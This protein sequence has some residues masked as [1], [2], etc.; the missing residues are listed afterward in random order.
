MKSKQLFGVMI[1]LSGL[2]LT[3]T[4]KAQAATITVT[5]VT[6]DTTSG[7]CTLREAVEAVN[8]RVA[9]DRCAA[10]TGGDEIILPAGTISVGSTRLR[11]MKNVTLK[12]QG[13]RRTTVDFAAASGIDFGN[14]ATILN[15][16]IQE[17]S[18]RHGTN[19]LRFTSSTKGI[20]SNVAVQDGTECVSAQSN[21][22]MTRVIVSGC[23][24]EGGGITNT[25]KLSV[26]SSSI[27]GN[28]GSMAGGIF[29][30]SG[31]LTV[32]NSTIGGNTVTTARFLLDGAGASG[33]LTTAGGTTTINYSTIA[34]NENTNQLGL[35]STNNCGA[36]TAGVGLPG[37]PGHDPIPAGVVNVT[38]SV[39]ANNTLALWDTNMDCAGTITSGGYNLLGTF[40]NNGCPRGAT[41]LAPAN[42]RLIAS[43]PEPIP[44]WRGGM[45]P[46]YLPQ[47]N[48]PLLNA[49]PAGVAPCSAHGLDQRMVRRG[50][51][52]GCEPGAVER[53]YALLVVD[54]PNVLSAGDA[55]THQILW[56]SGYHVTLA[57]DELV[58]AAQA[59]G[60]QTVV[61]SE[62][63]TSTV[64]GNRLRDVTSGVLV[65]EPSLFDD[66]AM[67][68]GGANLGSS[69]GQSLVRVQPTALSKMLGL[70]G[71]QIFN[72]TAVSSAQQFGWGVPAASADIHA[73]MN[74]NA[75]HAAFF[76]YFSGD[77]LSDGSDAAG[78]RTGF[79]AFPAAVPALTDSGA[80]AGYELFV[81][82][83][84]QT[85]NE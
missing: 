47:S 69:T 84:L 6:D 22:S 4:G 23:T 46:S 28:A 18:F 55:A 14:G 2:A 70:G 74:D 40:R 19:T 29:N 51:V 34:F 41:D 1:G 71:S 25:G 73:T 54:D 38:A 81:Q 78:H 26:A 21:V 49:I 85:A 66:M 50:I 20:L 83:I 3:L 82:A 48:S 64:L 37:F 39:V 58:T 61:I 57:S 17:V 13:Y 12:G 42:P 31:T 59:N 8:S 45:A 62:S 15:G 27:Y 53:S 16:I 63:V 35:C 77:P 24:G 60:V 7:N 67:T 52:G 72:M 10:G 68:G 5:S 80:S 65:L 79:F 56:S 76:D 11:F 44:M 9:V 30:F 32:T 75:A 36:L 33:V 43:S